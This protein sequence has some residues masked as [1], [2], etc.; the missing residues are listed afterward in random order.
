MLADDEK[1]GWR[2][3]PVRQDLRIAKKFSFF[4]MVLGKSYGRSRIV[5]AIKICGESY[6]S[7]PSCVLQMKEVNDM[8]REKRDRRGGL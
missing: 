4:S 8:N 5:F 6:F 1:P 3:V 2:A 7:P